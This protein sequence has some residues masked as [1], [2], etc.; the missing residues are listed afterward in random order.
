MKRVF[1][2]TI[3]AIVVSRAAYAG[4]NAMAD[5]KSNAPLSV[6][7]V[8]FNPPQAVFNDSFN[9]SAKL[10][11]GDI[12]LRRLKLLDPYA[13][14]VPLNSKVYHMCAAHIETDEEMQRFAVSYMQ[15]PGAIDGCPI[16]GR[17]QVYQYRATEDKW[18]DG[19][20]LTFDILP[21]GNFIATIQKEMDGQILYRE[22]WVKYVVPAPNEAFRVEG[23][24]WSISLNCHYNRTY[25][26][27]VIVR[28]E[29]KARASARDN[30]ELGY[31]RCEFKNFDYE[32]YNAAAFGGAPLPRCSVNAVFNGFEPK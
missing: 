7:S 1:L 5:L 15:G 32:D 29:E 30:C 22:K 25:H 23:D 28:L 3:F 27:N 24:A 14:Y 10:Q 16:K 31:R 20:E 6:E 21:D 13:K 11:A 2:A 18:M 9:A 19:T 8:S 4:V 17:L 26:P 12:Q